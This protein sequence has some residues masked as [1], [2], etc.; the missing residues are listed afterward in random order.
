MPQA[1]LK[2]IPSIGRL[3]LGTEFLPGEYILQVIVTDA[4]A[5]EKQITSQWIDF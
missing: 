1:D 2:R 4:A 3:Q 5:K